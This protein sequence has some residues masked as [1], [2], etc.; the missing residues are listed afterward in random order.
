VT[1][2]LNIVMIVWLE[3]GVS[4]M[5]WSSVIGSVLI[6]LLM[7]VYVLRGRSFTV[8]IYVN[9]ALVRYSLPLLVSGMCI[10][11]INSGDRL[12]LRWWV[13]LEQVGLYTLAYK[14]GMLVM[15]AFTPVELY[16]QSQMFEIMRRPEGHRRYAQWVTYVILLL[17]V[18]AVGVS[19][20]AR[21][22]LGIAVGPAFRDAA[23][24]VPWIAFACLIRGGAILAR[25]SFLV[26]GK[27]QFEAAVTG[28]AAVATLVAYAV[29]IPRFGT[30]GAVAATFVGFITLLVA[31]RYYAQK[32]R[33]YALEYRRLSLIGIAAAISLTLSMAY[34]PHALWQQFGWATLAFSVFPAIVLCS[35]FLSRE[36][37]EPLAGV[38][39]H[40]RRRKGVTASC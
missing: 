3:M 33:P 26:E 1:V 36:E 2:T 32:L 12:F 5:L 30:W 21:P 35:G 27:P 37:R 6:S 39:R 16:W 17:T 28:V 38:L 29:L 23:K 9:R 8:D 22:M 18:V 15:Y 34:R 4:G 20:F 31:G 7:A 24:Y 13:P 10:F 14:L 40:F 19:V 11:A 25:S